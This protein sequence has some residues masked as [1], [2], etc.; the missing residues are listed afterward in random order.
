METILPVKLIDTYDLTGFQQIHPAYRW[1]WASCQPKRL[2]LK[3]RLN[4][5]GLMRKK[6]MPLD[7]F[8]CELCMLQRELKL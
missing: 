4:T 6:N 5:R 7:S 1:L 2:L 8:D 3:N